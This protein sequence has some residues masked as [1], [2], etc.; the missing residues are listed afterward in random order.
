MKN[1]L[2]FCVDE[3]RAGDMGCAGNEVIKTPHLDALASDGVRFDRAYCNN[4]VC[5]PARATMFT[6]LM[7]RDHG[8]RV[9]G[10]RLNTA[11][12]AV[13]GHLRS[14][15][16][17]TFSAGKLHLTPMVPCP[18][19]N[20]PELSPESMSLWQSGKIKQL[21]EG[22][23]GFSETAFVGGHTDYAY[24]EF[25]DWIRDKGGDPELLKHENALQSDME[26]PR[27][28]KM[29][30][31]E[32]LHYNRFISDRTIDFLSRRR[33]DN[34]P[35]FAW[36]SYPDPHLDVAPPAP[37][38][39]MYNPEDIDVPKMSEDERRSLPKLQRLFENGTIAPFTHN[40]KSY[41]RRDF[42]E[43]IALS[44]GMIS[45]VDNEIGRVLA[46][47]KETGQYDNTMIVFISDHGDMLGGHGLSWKACHSWQEVTRIPLIVK[48][49]GGVKNTISRQVVSQ[50]D[51]FPTVA[52]FAGLD[53]PGEQRRSEAKFEYGILRKLNN[54]PGNDLCPLLCG[55]PDDPE[56]TAITEYDDPV[57]GYHIL[58]LHTNRYR[59]TVYPDTTVDDGELYD[60]VADP[61]EHKNLYHSEEAR[62]TKEELTFRLLTGYVNTTPFWQIPYWNS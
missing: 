22:Y 43:I 12:P 23:Y 49:P 59:F 4:P 2:I 7:P 46:A 32:E 21:P 41:T 6:G 60:L 35:F 3:M 9:N 19:E 28:Y 58:T 39:D 47:L 52:S 1:V 40:N 31:P 33:T 56:L 50:I 48:M 57:S 13:Q 18:E 45:H 25:I 20:T 37:W 8:L 34:Q 53:L 61:G 44:Y 10:Q 62:Q 55:T 17:Q 26:C 42:Q 14:Q 27:C 11:I 29:A 54:Y 16:Y 51:L 5:M 15:G 38:C 24:G 36:C 30:L